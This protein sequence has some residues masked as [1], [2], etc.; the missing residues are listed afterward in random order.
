MS[1]N[2]NLLEQSLDPETV[3]RSFVD[4]EMAE[5]RLPIDV[6]DI[7]D[8]GDIYDSATLLRIHFGRETAEKIAPKFSARLDLANNKKIQK[9][10]KYTPLCCCSTY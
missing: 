1:S 4:P 3:F 2:L 10:K 7:V 5:K 9:R 8:M 6:F